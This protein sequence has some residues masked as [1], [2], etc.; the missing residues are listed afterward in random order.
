MKNFGKFIAGLIFMIVAPIIRGYVVIKLWAWF[1]VPT[2]EMNELRLVEAI[3]IMFLIGY[4][5]ANNN[6]NNNNKEF[7]ERFAENIIFLLVLSGYVLFAGW[8]I[9]MFM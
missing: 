7:W 6:N 5:S 9:Q 8:I 4:L 3:G 2:F 1:I